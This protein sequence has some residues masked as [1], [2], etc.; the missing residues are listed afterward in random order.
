MRG[1]DFCVWE[2]PRMEVCGRTKVRRLSGQPTLGSQPY[3][4]GEREEARMTP[5]TSR[6]GS[7]D[8]ADSSCSLK[9]WVNG[10]QKVL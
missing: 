4:L 8:T 6:M 9:K 10:D 1:R 5:E 7:G 3:S 2:T